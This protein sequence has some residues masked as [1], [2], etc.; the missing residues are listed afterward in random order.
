LSG[1]ITITCTESS[2]PSIT[3]EATATDNCDGLPDISFADVI[4]PSGI[5]PQ[6]FTISRTWTAFDNCSNSSQCIQQITVADTIAPMIICPT[7][8]TVDC[9]ASIL[10]T[11][12]GFA[13]A[14]DDCDVNPI[15][16]YSDVSTP[17]DCP[18]ILT[19]IRS[20]T[21]VD[22]CGNSD[23]CIQNIYMIDDEGPSIL[24]PLDVSITC[25]IEIPPADVNGVIASDNCGIPIIIALVDV[26][27]DQT[28]LNGFTILR[29]YQ[30]SDLCDN[31]STC[32]QTIII[33]DTIVPIIFCPPTVVVSCA[34]EVP[35][36]NPLVVIATDNCG[37]Q[38]TLTHNGDLVSNFVC[39]NQ[40]VINRNYQA[41]DNCGNRV[42]VHRRSPYLIM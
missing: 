18:E 17:G 13:T 7:D 24:C 12:T 23:D 31:T 29:T 21:A 25:A 16:D 38:V 3:G 20:W 27:I 14:T 6:N 28:C 8:A 42:H 40:Y 30:A 2:D 22:A 15:V 10:P 34:T 39:V 36:A 35:V 19:I 33:N 1:P 37:N 32:L 41:I 4:T 11:E 9:T 26:T 5:C